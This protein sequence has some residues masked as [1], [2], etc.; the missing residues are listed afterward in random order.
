MS[1]IQ[2]TNEISTRLRSL[3]ESTLM[4]INFNRAHQLR[5]EDN[6]NIQ[7]LT[8]YQNAIR[9]VGRLAARYQNTLERDIRNCEQTVTNARETDQQLAQALFTTDRGA[10]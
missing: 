8:E 5:F 3:R 10:V 7:S 2:I 1:Q 6:R 9:V 4:N